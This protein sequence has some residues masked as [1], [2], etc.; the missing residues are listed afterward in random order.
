MEES[1]SKPLTPQEI[2]DAL[3]KEAPVDSEVKPLTPQEVQ[4]AL[5]NK[6][7]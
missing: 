6:G 2:Q 5:D 3:N 1:D 7:E 4:D